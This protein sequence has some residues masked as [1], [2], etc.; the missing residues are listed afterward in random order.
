MKQPI[1]RFN[2]NR[3]NQTIPVMQQPA[4]TTTTGSFRVEVATAR[5]AMPIANATVTIYSEVEPYNVITV[6]TTDVDGITEEI[7]L[8]TPPLEYSF[9]PDC[10]NRP[11][12]TYSVQV[13]F[14]RFYT[15]VYKNAQVFPNILSIQRANM[16][17]LPVDVEN[18]EMQVYVIPPIACERDRG[19]L[20]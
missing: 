8:P 16:I 9:D 5:D 1:H 19:G 11:Y 15:N 7:L 3:E 4:P 12:S 10:T 17:P 20:G 18:G 6:L 13:D 14:D 2:T